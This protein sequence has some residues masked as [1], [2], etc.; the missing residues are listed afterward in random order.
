MWISVG[1]CPAERCCC[2]SE[3]PTCASDASCQCQGDDACHELGL[4]YCD[5]ASCGGC[6]PHSCC[7]GG[8]GNN[9]NIAKHIKGAEQPYQPINQGEENNEDIAKQSKDVQQS[10]EQEEFNNLGKEGNEIVQGTL[11]LKH[12]WSKLQ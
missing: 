5:P 11:T 3:V 2:P 4:K 6:S 1:S 9:Q 12:H 7:C 10:D 8:E